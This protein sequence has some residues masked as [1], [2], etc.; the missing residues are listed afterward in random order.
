MDEVLKLYLDEKLG[1]A[2]TKNRYVSN[3]EKTIIN[4]HKNTENS[5]IYI[6]ARFVSLFENMCDN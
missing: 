3:T 2:L 4:M 5:A 1:K 6:Y